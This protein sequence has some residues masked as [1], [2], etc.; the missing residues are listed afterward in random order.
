MPSQIWNVVS[1]CVTCKTHQKSNQ[2][3]PL[4]PDSIPWSKLG[5]D[6]FE[7]QGKQYLVI[8]DYYSAFIDLIPIHIWQ[9][10]K[11][12]PTVSLS[13]LAMDYLMF[14]YLTMV[15]NFLVTSLNS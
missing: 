4:I 6:I 11:W 13:F 1:P 3:E 8:V 10:N 2:K 14:W 9:P 5:V 7:L 12:L 15:P